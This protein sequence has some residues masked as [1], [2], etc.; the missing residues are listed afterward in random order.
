M[1]GEDWH[2]YLGR[3]IGAVFTLGI[4]L[5]IVGIVW[6]LAI[7]FGV[8]AGLMWGG[9][10]GG[11]IGLVLSL[12]FGRRRFAIGGMAMMMGNLCIILVVVGL[13]VWLVRTIVTC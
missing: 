1:Q 3:I 13:L 12:I 11:G 4:L 6:S 7:G 10:V 9:I 8:V 2:E 5:S